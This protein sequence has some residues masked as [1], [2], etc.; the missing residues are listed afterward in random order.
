M[1]ATGDQDGGLAVWPTVLAVP[2]SGNFR[3]A[4]S[5][6]R[7]QDVDRDREHRVF[8][9]PYASALV[10]VAHAAMEYSFIVE[11]TGGG[12]EAYEAYQVLDR[13]VDAL[14]ALRS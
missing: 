3:S 5:E 1:T 6:T 13:A 11:I 4:F 12:V 14:E 8:T 10:E 2:E 9:Q 7:P